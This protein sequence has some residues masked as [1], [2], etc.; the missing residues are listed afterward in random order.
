MTLTPGVAPVSVLRTRVVDLFSDRVLFVSLDQW[1]DQP[2]QFFPDGR[3]QRNQAPYT[4]VYA[5]P[6]IVDAIQEFKVQSHND[7]AEFGAATGGIIN[8]VTKSGTYDL[9]GTVW[10][11]LRNNAFDARN[12]FLANVTPFKQ[13]MFG[14]TVG[15]PVVLPK[16]Y[17]GK[18]KTFFFLGYQGF[19]YR[20]N[21]ETLF[22]VPTAANLNGDLSDWPNQIYNPYTTRADPSRPGSYIRDPFPRNQIPSSML[23]P[24][25]VLYAQT[26]LPTPVV[27]GVA[28]R[29]ALDTTP[30]KQ[31]Q[32]EYTARVDQYLGQKDFF[33][34]RYSGRR[35]DIDSSGGRQAIANINENRARNVGLSWVHTFSASTVMQIQYGRTLVKYPMGAKFRS[36]PPDFLQQV[37]LSEQ[38][39]G[40]FIGG[41]QLIPGFNVPDFFTGGEGGILKSKPVDIDQIK[42]NLSK[43]IGNH[44][45]KFGGEF[46]QTTHFNDATQLSTTFNAFQTNN[47]QSP[48]APGARWPPTC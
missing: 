24:G 29:N 17:N 16:I 14:G 27:T 10:E 35:Q 37:G 34:F 3:R 11:Y 15:G 23:D 18:N 2:Q 1:P 48:A 39:A 21:A 30:F 43:I 40:G 8:V 19:R 42:G 28:D 9:H 5:V 36:L 20:R 22:R 47:P 32:E 38:F 13:N 7:Q 44:T 45:L 41:A 33:W 6:P 25:M 4:S 46:N 12:R 31:S 26:T